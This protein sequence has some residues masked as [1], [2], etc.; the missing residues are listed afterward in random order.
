VLAKDIDDTFVHNLI[1]GEI[2]GHGIV[3]RFFVIKVEPQHIK[4]QYLP[5]LY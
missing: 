5:F 3:T 4:E 2:S 1:Y